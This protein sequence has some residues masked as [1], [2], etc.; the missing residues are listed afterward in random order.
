M[1]WNGW[2]PKTVSKMISTLMSSEVLDLEVDFDLDLT[3]GSLDAGEV[4]GI[5]ADG[6]V[7]WDGGIGIASIVDG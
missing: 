1:A 6:V 3:S 5:S 4:D 2:I 7:P